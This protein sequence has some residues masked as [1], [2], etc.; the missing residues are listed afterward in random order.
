MKKLKKLS[1]SEL[2]KVKG[3]SCPLYGGSTCEF[4][5]LL[6]PGSPYTCTTCMYNS[7]GGSTGGY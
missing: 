3:G 1:F 5:Y 4:L 6:L 2:K 7:G